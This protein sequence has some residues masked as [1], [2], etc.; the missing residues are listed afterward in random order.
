MRMC[1]CLKGH[2][3]TEGG[4]GP[5]ASEGGRAGTTGCHLAEV[6]SVRSRSRGAAWAVLLAVHM[7]A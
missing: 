7:L 2:T 3:G 6:S 5:G 4:R 1:V